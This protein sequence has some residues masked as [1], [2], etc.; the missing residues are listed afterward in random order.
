MDYE[1][2]YKDALEWIRDLYPTMEGSVKEDAEHFFPELAESEDE[3]IRNRIIGYLKQDIEEHPERK[4]RINEMLA[5]L[6][7]QKEQSITANDLDEEIHRFFNDCIDVHEAKLYGSIN[8]RV[9]PVDCYEIT[10]RHFAKWAEKQKKQKPAECGCTNDESEYDKGYREGH[11]FGL[12]QTED[13]MLPGGKTFSGLIP[14]WINAPSELQPA[15]KYHGKNVVVMHENNGGFR[16][17]FID[18]EKATTIHLPEDTLFVE[19]WRK[20]PAEWSEEDSRILYNVIAFVGYAAGQRGVRDN[21]FIEANNWL[22]SLPERFNLQPKVTWKPT[23]GQIDA[24][25]QAVIKSRGYNYGLPLFGLYDDLK[26]L[27]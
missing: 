19:G 3:R 12:R 14:C 21:E 13:Y 9:I 23:K 2:A 15:H 26:K 22:K 16:C 17:C 25:Y 10:A 27:M 11:R 18:D 6:E 8:E 24:L 5:Y 4:E 7:K 20:Q 1:K